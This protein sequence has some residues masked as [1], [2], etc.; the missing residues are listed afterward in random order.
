M[1][2]NI[3][4]TVHVRAE[5]EYVKSNGDI[6]LWIKST[7]YYPP[8]KPEDIVHVEPR[9]LSVGD[10]VRWVRWGYYPDHTGTIL[11]I[12]D[13]FAWYKHSDGLSTIPLKDLSRV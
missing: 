7:G 6:E 8:V 5:V 2:V 12:H 4:D 10:K 1:K 3:G 9:P 13:G 11:H